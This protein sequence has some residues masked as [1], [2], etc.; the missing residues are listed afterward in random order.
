MMYMDL[1]NIS[2]LPLDLNS[3]PESP[4]HS[5]GNQQRDFCLIADINFPVDLNSVP[6]RSDSSSQN[7]LTNSC[8]A[9]DLNSVPGSPSLLVDLNLVP[10]NCCHSS[11]NQQEESCFHL[12][13]NNQLH[14]L[15][16]KRKRLVVYCLFM[17]IALL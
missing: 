8:L 4:C 1:G 15:H 12:E 2:P 13:V 11:E 5:S 16:L 17:R 6:E 7:Q 14:N 9:I 10:E 3:E